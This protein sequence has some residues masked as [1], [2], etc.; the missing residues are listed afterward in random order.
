MPCPRCGADLRRDEIRSL[1]G[2]DE[3]V[4]SCS[5]CGL[6]IGMRRGIDRSVRERLDLP[7]CI[8]RLVVVLAILGTIALVGGAL[9]VFLGFQ[10]LDD[11]PGP[12]VRVGVLV[13]LG[14]RLGRFRADGTAR[15]FVPHNPWLVTVGLFLIYTGFW[16]FYAACNVP[17]ISPEGIGGLITGET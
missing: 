7:L 13:V 11:I 14:P 8:L 17:I 1:K 2:I 3:P 9:V 10:M 12:A 4:R 5:A 6:G 15:A 16:G